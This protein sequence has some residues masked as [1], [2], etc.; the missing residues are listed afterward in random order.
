[1]W[2]DLFY[3]VFDPGRLDGSKGAVNLWSIPCVVFSLVFH[4]AGVCGVAKEIYKPCV[5]GLNNNNNNLLLF[6]NNNNNYYYYAHR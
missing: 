1:M 4:C 5:A 6:Y 2:N 3:T